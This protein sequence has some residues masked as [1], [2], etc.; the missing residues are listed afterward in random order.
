M[1]KALL[2]YLIFG[3]MS[4]GLYAVGGFSGWWRSGRVSSFFGSGGSGGH[5]G[6]WGF[7]GGGFRGG[8]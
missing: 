2:A 8:K 1:T 6:G 5:G 4:L 3:G 7:G